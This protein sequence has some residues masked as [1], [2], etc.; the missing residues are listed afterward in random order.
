MTDQRA[1]QPQTPDDPQRAANRAAAKRID[2]VNEWL[3]LGGAL[4]PDEYERFRD[5]RITHVV[6]LRENDDAD[7]E[8]LQVLGISRRHAANGRPAAGVRQ[9]FRYRRFGDAVG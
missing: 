1:G 4:S 2:R 8:R 5:A 9:S 3:H 6:D 7:V